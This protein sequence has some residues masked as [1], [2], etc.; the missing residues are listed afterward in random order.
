M[1]PAGLQC[2]PNPAFALFVVASLLTFLFAV[3]A[4]KE[5]TFSLRTRDYRAAVERLRAEEVRP[6]STWRDKRH[7]LIVALTRASISALPRLRFVALRSVAAKSHH[8]AQQSCSKH[9]LA[10]S[11]HFSLRFA[12]MRTQG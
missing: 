9:P 4:K 10:I 7:A 12:C 11:C 3:P 6:T 1:L 5:I 8:L 2:H